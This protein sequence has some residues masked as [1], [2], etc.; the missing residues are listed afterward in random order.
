MATK[1]PMHRL[2][3][4]SGRQQQVFTTSQARALEIPSSTL[5]DRAKR[6]GLAHLGRD[7]WAVTGSPNTYLRKLW[8]AKLRFGDEVVFTGRTVLWLRRIITTTPSTIDIL[9]RPQLHLR[10]RPGYCFVRSP[11]LDQD[12]TINLEGFR[13]V[14]VYRAFTDAAA[15]VPMDSLLRWLPAMDR[16]RLG[17]LEGLAEYYTC[18]GRFVGIVDLRAAVTV[19]LTGL[20]HSGAEKIARRLLKA[21]DL[22][23]Y[24]R[25]YPVRI[26]GRTIAEIDLAYPKVLYGAEVDGPHHQLAEVAAADK[27]RDRRLARAGWIIDRFPH[28]H[29]LN[30]PEGFVAE[31]RAGLGGANGRYPGTPNH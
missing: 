2:L 12:D 25:P 7:L 22:A 24:V 6:L 18:R 4:Q 28:N 11:R 21:A 17:T 30:D 1:P 3:I 8:A 16:L 13:C 27:A 19:L 10:P 14:S 20:P 29:V 15:V 31:V 9:I 5:H 23:P 26:G